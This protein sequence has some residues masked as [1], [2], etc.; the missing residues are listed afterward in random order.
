MSSPQ[1]TTMLGFFSWA[2]AGLVIHAKPTRT[3]HNAVMNILF[4]SSHPNLPPQERGE[5]DKLTSNSRY[6]M[7]LTEYKEPAPHGSRRR[8]GYFCFLSLKPYLRTCLQ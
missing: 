7:H 1:M 8:S 4:I 3:A 2:T 5:G 6:F